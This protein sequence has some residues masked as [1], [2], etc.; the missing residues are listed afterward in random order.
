MASRIYFDL[1]RRANGTPYLYGDLVAPAT[2]N[3]HVYLCTVAGTSA[4]S[5]PT[6]G[7]GAGGATTDGGVTW[8]EYN[9]T[10]LTYSAAVTFTKNPQWGNIEKEIKYVQ[11]M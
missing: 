11:P 7:T 10:G 4:G 6:F 9:P 1:I 5:P 3:N 2:L 8:T